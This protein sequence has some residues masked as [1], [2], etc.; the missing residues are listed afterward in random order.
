MDNKRWRTVGRFFIVI[1]VHFFIPSKSQIS[2]N[3]DGGRCI[4]GKS[5]GEHSLCPPWCNITRLDFSLDTTPPYRWN[6]YY[7]EGEEIADKRK[8]RGKEKR[9]L[10]TDPRYVAGF[11]RRK[12]LNGIDV[13]FKR[14]SECLLFFW[15]FIIR[16]VVSIF[17]RSL[18]IMRWKLSLLNPSFV[19][20]FVSSLF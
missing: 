6:L 11:G 17:F 20:L 16:S 10:P 2:C 18:S 7:F 15:Y 14:P 3:S 12:E 5:G 19:W 1:R 8:R 4:G 13:F 9:E